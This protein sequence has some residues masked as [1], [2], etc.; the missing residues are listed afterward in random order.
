MDFFLVVILLACISGGLSGSIAH[1]KGWSSGNWFLAGLLFGPL[2]LIASA[3]L[4]DRKQ[5][6]YLFELS[7]KYGVSQ[8]LLEPRDV[9][10]VIADQ[11]DFVTDRQ[12]TIDEIWSLV[13]AAV[14]DS[15]H[16]IVSRELSHLNKMSPRMYVSSSD[17]KCLAEFKRVHLTGKGVSYWRMFLLN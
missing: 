6:H 17:D 4:P 9:V 15:M 8:D 5:R 10:P 2:G 13:L 14:P 7:K 3:G 16:A 12:T 11:Y 1:A